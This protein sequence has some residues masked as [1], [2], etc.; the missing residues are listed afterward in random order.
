MPEKTTRPWWHM[1]SI[2]AM[3]KVLPP[4]S[5]KMM[6]ENAWKSVQKTDGGGVG[7]RS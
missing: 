3:R 7:E 5:E 4:I 1:A 6:S 2:A